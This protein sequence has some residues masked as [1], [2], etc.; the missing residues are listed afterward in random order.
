MKQRV[1]VNDCF[2]SAPA[3]ISDAVKDALSDP[4]KVVG[5]TRDELSSGYSLKAFFVCDNKEYTALFLSENGWRDGFSRQFNYPNQIHI[6][7]DHVE[8]SSRNP[9]AAPCFIID[10]KGVV[11]R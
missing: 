6:F 11:N 3:P 2:D 9:L 1:F 8:N 5:L 10:G 7:N 4:N